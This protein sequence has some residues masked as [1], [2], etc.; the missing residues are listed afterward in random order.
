MLLDFVHIRNYRRLQDCTITFSEKETIFVGANNS[1]KTSAMN[2]IIGFLKPICDITL[3]EVTVTNWPIIEGMGQL[4]VSEDWSRKNSPKVED[5]YPIMP[6]VDF[7]F[8]VEGS[9]YYK[10][11]NLIPTLDSEEI[12]RVGVR[13]ALLPKVHKGNLPLYVDFISAYQ[14]AKDLKESTRGKHEDVRLFPQTLKDFIDRKDNIKKYFEIRYYLLDEANLEGNRLTKEPTEDEILDGNPLRDLVKIDV[15]EAQRGFYDAT[16]LHSKESLRLTQ[17]LREYFTK[18]FDTSE[19]FSESDLE[20]LSVTQKNN[21]AYNQTISNALAPAFHELHQINYPGLDNPSLKFETSLTVSE[22]ITHDSVVKFNIPH[23]Q[24]QFTLPENYNGLGYLN[25]LSITFKLIQFRDEWT[26]GGSKSSNEEQPVEPLHIVFIEEPEAHLHAQVQQVF[27]S[28]AYNYLTENDFLKKN[29]GFETQL[30]VSTHS[31]HIVQD[32]KFDKLRYFKREFL[33]GHGLPISQV[34]ELKDTFG[35]DQET[36]KFVTRYL[37]LTHCNIFFA[38][39]VIMVEG[40]AERILF[41]KF[42][43]AAG[44]SSYYLSIIEINGSHAHRFKPLIERLGIKTLVVTDLDAQESSG[45][46]QVL[47]KKK[48]N[49]ITNND[50]IKKWL[51]VSSIDDLLALPSEKKE[52][53]GHCR[54]AYQI[55]IPIVYKEGD[56]KKKACPYTFEDALALTNKELFKEEKGER[57]HGLL[58]KFQEAF[59]KET[60]LKCQEALMDALKTGVKAE[61]AI[62]LLTMDKFDDLKAPNYIQEGLVWLKTK[63]DP[64]VEHLKENKDGKS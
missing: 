63:L 54:V 25:L 37:N 18:N 26:K 1:G 43:A 53:Q 59:T 41:P 13:L 60:L 64:E 17:Q 36:N 42:L 47:P 48:A 61:F 2:A 29:K 14:K 21:E 46:G 34:V 7:W 6:S 62:D 19:E 58:K 9:E 4:W 56:A 24:A 38:D 51:N 5:W 20:R 40:A 22:A 44:L 50:T 8:R 15:I 30:V 12:K 3:N 39:A 16:D 57:T 33:P 49:Q 10:V 31:N 28:K 52:V 23:T 35:V 11:R 27:I 55:E 32:V 45:K